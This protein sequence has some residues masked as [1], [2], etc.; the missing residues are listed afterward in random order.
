MTITHRGSTGGGNQVRRV[1]TK[2]HDRQIA[3][4]LAD[5]QGGLPI[6]FRPPLG[7]LEPYTGLSRTRLYRLASEGHI[8]SISLRKPGMLKGTRLFN[9]PSLLAYLDS[10]P[11]Q[12]PDIAEVVDGDS[13]FEQEGGAR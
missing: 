9:M 1:S 2:T 10:Q 11:H 6:W 5:R 8:R 4:L 13:D 7:H 3:D 12:A